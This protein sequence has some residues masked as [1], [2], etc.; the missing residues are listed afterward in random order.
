MV[1]DL[2]LALGADAHRPLDEALGPLRHLRLGT[3]GALS[4]CQLHTLVLQVQGRVLVLN[5]DLGLRTSI[6][7]WTLKALS[8]RHQM[9]GYRARLATPGDGRAVEV[10]GLD[11]RILL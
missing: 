5:L 8:V 1:L 2:H 7:I 11:A 6:T 3:A 10:G 4:V 9:E